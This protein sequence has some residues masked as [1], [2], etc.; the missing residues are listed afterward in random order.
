[1]L[2]RPDTSFFRRSLK[3]RQL[4]KQV[5]QNSLPS[6]LFNIFFVVTAG[7]YIALSVQRITPAI[8]FPFWQLFIYAVILVGVVY[9]FKYG[10]LKFIGWVFKVTKLA[11][12][13]IFLIFL[14]NKILAILLLPLII[15]IALTGKPANTIAWTL[16]GC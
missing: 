3:Q 1:M 9:L 13:Y 10:I 16:S 5:V 11:D 15:I 7:I 12:N 6:L 4:K 2:F 14:V 8:N